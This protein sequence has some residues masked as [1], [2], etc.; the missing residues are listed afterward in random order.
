MSVKPA[1]T[2]VFELPSPREQCPIACLH[3]IHKNVEKSSYEP[4]SHEE[5]VKILKDGRNM[6]IEFLN[7]YPHDDEISLD[8]IHALPYVKLGHELGYKVKTV[9]S[10]T[11]AEGIKKLLPYLY[12]IA[13]SVDAMSVRA[14]TSMRH[15]RFH[16]GLLASI[17]VVEEYKK[18]HTLKATALVVVNRETLER[19]EEEVESIYQLNIFNKIKVLEMLPIGTAKS[20]SYQELDSKEHL[21]KLAALRTKYERK[22]DIGTP[23]WR[24]RK[25]Q[26]RGC[27]LGYK[28]LV[29][30]PNGQLSG[31]SLLF[32]LN[33]LVGNIRA[34]KSVGEAW[35]KA[36]DFFRHK[37]NFQVEDICRSCEFYK[38]D[39]CW[40]GCGARSLIFGAKKELTRSCGIESAEHS[41]ELYEEYLKSEKHLTF[42]TPSKI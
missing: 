4:L 15:E 9:S 11:N 12:R 5:I 23:L 40:G 21:D 30:G 35:E 10:G 14:Y 36:F 22:V 20:L 19:V 33:N 32:Y 18:E 26:Q 38:H 31:C 24:V 16:N 39:L 13:L 8:P 42:L 29:I 17:K 1:K 25:E 34:Y 41:Q 28:D 37:E 27:Q 2:L 6:R 7:I 3:C